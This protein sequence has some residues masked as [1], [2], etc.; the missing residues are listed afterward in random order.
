[1]SREIHFVLA[2]DL[3]KKTVSI[4]DGSYQARW[5]SNEQV[6]DNDLFIWRE[7]LKGEYEL[8]LKL[9]NEKK[10]EDD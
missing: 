5:S 10:L 9:L 1:M 4:D 2:V 3:D 8:A 6:W 7:F